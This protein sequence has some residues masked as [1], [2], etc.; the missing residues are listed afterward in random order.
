MTRWLALSLSVYF[1]FL[2]STSFPPFTHP[3]SES[4]ANNGLPFTT[5]WRSN[6]VQ[7]DVGQVS[8]GYVQ[9]SSLYVENSNLIEFYV[10]V[11]H[12]LWNN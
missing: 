12:G 2:L 10:C 3:S 4:H 1:F 11:C 5:Q 7:G 6:A 8:L 9:M